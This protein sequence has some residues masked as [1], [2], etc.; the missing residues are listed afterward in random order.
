M[1]L[2]DVELTEDQRATLAKLRGGCRCHLHAPCWVCVDPI[3]VQE[4]EALAVLRFEE[5]RLL[6]EVMLPRPS[7]DVDYMKHVRDLCKGGA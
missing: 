6:P 3:T 2:A 7:A 4:A 1:K 5:P